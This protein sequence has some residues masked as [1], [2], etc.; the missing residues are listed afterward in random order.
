MMTILLTL[1]FTMGQD[2]PTPKGYINDHARVMKSSDV[3]KL[4]LV[5]EELHQKTGAVLAFLI[6]PSVKPL[7]INTYANELMQK[8][9]FGDKKL[10]NGMIV[11]VAIKDRDYA[12]RTGY[13]LE[14]D[15]PDG[16]VGQMGRDYFVPLFKQKKYSEGVFNFSAAILSVLAQRYNVTLTGAPKA[17]KHKSKGGWGS[18]FSLIIL[19][20]IIGSSIGY[21]RRGSGGALPLLLLFGMSGS[22]WRGGG[23]GGSFGGGGGGGFGGFGGGSFGGGGASGSW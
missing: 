1:L 14:G 22:G 21:G 11:V 10:D 12:I 4:N 20:L 2:F 7:D 8:W 23:G 5:I 3:R 9:K 19:V 6:L 17:R 16:K 18:I 13:G 15:L